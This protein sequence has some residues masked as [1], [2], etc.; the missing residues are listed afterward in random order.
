MSLNHCNHGGPL[1]PPTLVNPHPPLPEVSV[2]IPLLDHRGLAIECV[3]SW[4]REQTYPRECFEVIVVTDGSDPALDLRVK[5]L[6]ERQDRMI[7]HA[8]TNLFL[9]G[10]S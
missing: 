7:K 4:V 3:E 10:S 9:L 6:L 5:A 1:Q 8:T 2:I